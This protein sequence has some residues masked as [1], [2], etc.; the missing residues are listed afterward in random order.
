MSIPPKAIYRFNA[1]LTKIPMTFFTETEN[2]KICMELQKTQ[3]AKAILRKKNI[4]GDITLPD[5]K[6]YYRAIVI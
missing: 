1:I 2:S 5:F 3:I 6:F 4:A